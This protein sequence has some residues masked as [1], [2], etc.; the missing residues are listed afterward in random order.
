MEHGLKEDDIE[1]KV[2]YNMHMRVRMWLGGM[3]F[4]TARDDG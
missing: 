2:G 3:G 4:K 1:D